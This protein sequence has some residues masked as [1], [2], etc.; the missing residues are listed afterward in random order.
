MLWI[1]GYRLS[2][3]SLAFGGLLYPAN[4]MVSRPLPR[5]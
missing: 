1:Q 5:G 3:G 2:A 4:P